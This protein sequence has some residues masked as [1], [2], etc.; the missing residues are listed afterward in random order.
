M[1]KVDN[2]DIKCFNEIVP[3]DKATFS[4]FDKID[5]N[6]SKCPHNY[7]FSLDNAVYG[8]LFSFVLYWYYI[9]RF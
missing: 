1:F 3:F 4:Q 6:I 9:S 5:V 8:Q 7:L 2:K